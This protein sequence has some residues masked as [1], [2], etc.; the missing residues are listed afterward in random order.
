MES[1][2]TA[3]RFVLLGLLLTC[4]PLLAAVPETVHPLEPPDRSSPRGTIRTLLDAVDET[5]DL[6]RA[7]D[8]EY[9]AAY[10]VARRCV[11]ASLIAPKGADRA[12][13][14]AALLLKEILDRIE[15]PPNSEIPDAGVVK[16]EA[17]N[18]WIL[19]HTEIELVRMEEGDHAGEFVFSARTVARLSEFYERVKH[20]P[21]RAGRRG[22]SYD[23][24][25]FTSRSHVLS[26]IVS[27]L[28]GWLRQEVGGQLRWQWVGLVLVLVSATA[29]WG[30][31]VWLGR[32]YSRP[33]S[34]SQGLKR[35]WPFV[36]PATLI[37]IALWTRGFVFTKL[38]IWGRVGLVVSG[39]MVALAMVGG[40]WLS[41]VLITRGAEHF[42]RF[43]KV[44]RPLRKQLIRVSSRGF[45]LVVVL[46]WFFFGGQYLGLPLT[47]IV[48][49]LGVGGLAVAL[50]AQSSIEN[51]IGGIS[52]YVD[53]PV[54]VGDWLRLGDRTGS[55]EEVGLRS[56]KIRTREGTLITVPNAEFAKLDLENL[57]RRDKTILLHTLCLSL[58]TSSDQVRYLLTKLQ[59][60]LEEHSD[61]DGTLGSTKLIGIGQYSLDL[62]LLSFANTTNMPEFKEIRQDV[63]LKAIAIVEDA[64]AS[65][66]MPSSTLR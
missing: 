5:L 54:R 62:E 26:N 37:L 34:E 56:A 50:A 20:L 43:A 61:L 23:E 48:A 1:T 42:I 51:L 30:L 19:P 60:M 7:G 31:L 18:A 64:G 38:S 39:T 65:I 44:E 52:L 9:D 58:E 3:T 35:L 22:A 10:E 41:V 17:M 36:A 47:A 13:G 2:T 8:P 59:A 57:S 11:D 28:P 24:F 15:L 6:Y 53:Q 4:W 40:A 29:L 16:R 55:L 49:G 32:R 46:A 25:R 14:E 63:L 21:Y 27:R 66:A 45:S 33:V 12:V